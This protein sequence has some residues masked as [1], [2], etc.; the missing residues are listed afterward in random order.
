MFA[1]WVGRTLKSTI[2][3]SAVTNTAVPAV[4]HADYELSAGDNTLVLSRIS[5]R[6]IH[7][8]FGLCGAEGAP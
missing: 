1:G 6:A 2:R 8:A 5:D 3:R 7:D 4:D